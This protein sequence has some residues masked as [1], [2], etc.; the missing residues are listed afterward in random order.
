MPEDFESYIQRVRAHRAELRE[1]VA[2]VEE[3]LAI[4]LGKGIAWRQR[5]HAALA[6][7]AHD[8]ADH[9]DLTERPGGLYDG[10]RTNASRLTAAVDRLTEE[11]AALREEIAGSLAVLENEV[12]TT[13][14]LHGLREAVTSLMGRLVRHR[15]RGGDL[16]YEAYEVDIGGSG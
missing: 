3:A 11:H 16:V 15:Q 12:G 4:P 10:V 2:A 5:V 8:F 1:S 13:A 7:L 14:D 6:E 9:V